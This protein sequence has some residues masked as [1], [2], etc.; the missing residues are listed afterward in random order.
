MCWWSTHPV[1]PRDAS[2]ETKK[3]IVELIKPREV[4]LQVRSIRPISKGGVLVEAASSQA[5]GK[6]FENQAMKD[7]GFQVARPKVALPKVMIYDVPSDISEDEV[8]NCLRSQNPILRPSDETIQ[9]GL[10]LVKRMPVRDRS[11]EHWVLECNPAVRDWLMSE[12]RVYIDWS[13]CRVKDFL[14]V[15]RCYNC[16][17]YGHSSKFCRGKRTCA[18][19]V[20]DHDRKDCPSKEKNF[21][22]PA[23]AK[24]NRKEQH[25]VNDTMCPVYRRAAEDSVRRTDY[26][27]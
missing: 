5:A 21:P 1:D 24:V 3:R 18:H 13:S 25:Y 23:C 2:V 11:V 14:N 4:S 22:C 20:G 6:I 10:R 15:T 27:C 9:A 7:G 12:G 16:Q 26:G 19:C 8:R 17:G